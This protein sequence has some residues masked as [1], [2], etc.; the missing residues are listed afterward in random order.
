MEMEVQFPNSDSGGSRDDNLGESFIDVSFTECLHALSH[1]Y[2][3]SLKSTVSVY[4]LFFCIFKRRLLCLVLCT[5]FKLLLQVCTKLLC[6]NPHERLGSRSVEDISNHPWFIDHV[7][8]EGNEHSLSSEAPQGP[9]RLHDFNTYKILSTVQN[10]ASVLKN[11]AFSFNAFIDTRLPCPFSLFFLF[12]LVIT[13]ASSAT[14]CN[15]RLPLAKTFTRTP[16]RKSGNSRR[17]CRRSPSRRT[18]T[19]R[20]GPGTSARIRRSTGKS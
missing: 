6:K 20:C 10:T 12:L 16:R 13:Q 17:T 8:I 9:I 11:A 19:K 4:Y 5:S 1:V 3:H 14:V 18:T 15:R 7:D 2:I